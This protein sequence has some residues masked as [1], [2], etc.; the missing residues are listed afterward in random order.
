MLKPASAIKAKVPMSATGMVSRGMMDARKVRKN[1]KITSATNTEASTMVVNTLLIERSI[2]TELSLATSISTPGGRSRCTLTIS[3][4]TP[5]DSSSGFAV[6]W[7]ITPIP[8]ASRPFNRTLERSSTGACCTRA[9]SA[10]RIGCPFTVRM[11]IWAKSCGRCKSV[12]AV[13]LNSR[14]RLSIRPAG[15]SRF[16]RRTASSRS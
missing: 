2:K 12:A 11:T 14:S 5:S 8:M 13:T 9:T 1:T 15:T 4:R 10:M 16:D 3:C 7:R 6:A